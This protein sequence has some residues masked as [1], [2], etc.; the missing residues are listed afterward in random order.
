V[1]R[2]KERCLLRGQICD[3]FVGRYEILPSCDEASA[4][5]DEEVSA[6]SFNKLCARRYLRP[7]VSKAAVESAQLCQSRS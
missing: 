4:A 7:N 5:D 1:L 3:A 2:L 6:S